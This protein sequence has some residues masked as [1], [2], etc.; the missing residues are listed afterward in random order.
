MNEIWRVW[1]QGSSNNCNCWKSAGS[2]SGS[3][4]G[5]WSGSGSE[6]R[7]VFLSVSGPKSFDS[8]AAAL[9]SRD[10]LHA[11]CNMQQHPSKLPHQT[12]LHSLVNYI[13]INLGHDF[14]NDYV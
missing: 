5:S 12:Q 14:S 3:G 7:S 6:S 2:A 11:A 10:R 9:S 8:L 1:L 13:F 4:S